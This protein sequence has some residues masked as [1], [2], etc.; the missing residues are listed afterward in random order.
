MRWEASQSIGS[1]DVAGR[2]LAL[3]GLLAFG[4][5]SVALAGELQHQL[6]KM[7]IGFLTSI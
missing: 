2:L 1:N 7:V 6:M 4:L 5:A 3:A